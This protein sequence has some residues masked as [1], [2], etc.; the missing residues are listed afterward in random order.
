MGVVVL[1]A[2][3]RADPLVAQLDLFIAASEHP[4]HH[5]IRCLGGRILSVTGCH[6]FFQEIDSFFYVREYAAGAAKGYAGKFIAVFGDVISRDEG[7]HTVAE[8]EV[9]KIRI[10]FFDQGG[11]RVLVLH[12]GA[13]TLVAPIAP[14]VV[15]HGGFAVTY[16]IIGRDDIA[17][18]HKIHDHMEISSGM[19]SEAVHQL[20]DSAWLC[21]RNVNPA[22]HIISLIK[23][24][25]TYFM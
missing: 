12:H 16:V 4:A 21:C 3:I 15:H 14:G 10:H 22:L 20:N 25:K 11:E 5:H 2:R 17:G 6:F 18:L 13:E 1:N 24:F 23:R 9:R 8:H 7:T 19:L